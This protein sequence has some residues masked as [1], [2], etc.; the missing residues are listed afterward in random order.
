MGRREEMG[1]RKR[2]SARRSPEIGVEGLQ[3]RVVALEGDLVLLLHAQEHRQL[4][5]LACVKARPRGKGGALGEA[6]DR[7][8]QCAL[9]L[10]ARKFQRGIRR[11]RLTGDLE[12]LRGGRRLLAQR[13]QRWEVD[14][15]DLRARGSERRGGAR[16]EKPRVSVRSRTS[17]RASAPEVRRAG[18]PSALRLPK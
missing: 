13:W 18:G 17:P 2:P 5:R 4:Q 7:R 14:E 15:G 12:L 6:R 8:A 10:R 3:L 11:A 16:H 9:P 1:R